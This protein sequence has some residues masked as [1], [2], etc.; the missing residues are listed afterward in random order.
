MNITNI[1]L[2]QCTLNDNALFAQLDHYTQITLD[3]LWCEYVHET[4]QA[5]YAKEIEDEIVQIRMMH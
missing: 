3:A 2:Q 5:Q 1:M 4:I